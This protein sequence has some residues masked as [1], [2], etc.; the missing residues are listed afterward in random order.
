[1]GL[2]IGKLSLIRNSN[3]QLECSCGSVDVITI[4]A[5]NIFAAKVTRESSVV[6]ADNRN[7]S[8]AV[9]KSA[10]TSSSA[11]NATEMES[12][13]TF[14]ASKSFVLIVIAANKFAKIND[15]VTSS[16]VF[17]TIIDSF[18]NFSLR[19]LYSSSKA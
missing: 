1:M 19:S 4:V 17:I 8:T 7:N 9:Q 18:L 3:A 11:L 10:S 12:S 14:V 5:G 13:G 6:D 2:V 16:V 15:E